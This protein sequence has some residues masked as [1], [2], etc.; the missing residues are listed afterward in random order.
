VRSISARAYGAGESLFF[1]LKFVL[2]TSE[3]VVRLEIMLRDYVVRNRKR[4]VSFKWEGL[5]RLLELGKWLKL[6]GLKLKRSLEISQL[7]PVLN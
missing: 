3:K 5:Q 2:L 1:D 6:G 4:V 7:H